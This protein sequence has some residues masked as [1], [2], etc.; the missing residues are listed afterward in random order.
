[1]AQQTAV[2]WLMSEM[3]KPDMYK[4]WPTLLERAKEME[5]EQIINAWR[6]GD[7]DSMY[8]SRQLDNDAEQYY[9]ETFV[10]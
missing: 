5:K 4:I 10:K 6:N 3:L 1:M 8:N 9:N 7:N 2:D